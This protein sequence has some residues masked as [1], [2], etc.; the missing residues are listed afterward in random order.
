MNLLDWLHG[1]RKTYYNPVL[2]PFIRHNKMTHD[3]VQSEDEDTYDRSAEG[4]LSLLHEPDDAHPANCISSLTEDGTHRPALDIDTP[5]KLRE[6]STPGNYHLYFEDI[7]L[8]WK[9][10]KKLLKALAKAGIIEEGYARVSIKRKQ[11]ILRLFPNKH[12]APED[13]PF[14]G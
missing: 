9:Q 10:Y 6:S 13:Q 14:R 1:N 7:E 2:D 11:T 5:I 4:L 8:T 3:H 12:E